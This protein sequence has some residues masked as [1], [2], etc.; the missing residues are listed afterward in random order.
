MSLSAKFDTSKIKARFDA[1]A[2]NAEVAARPAA[3]AG[4]QVYYDEVKVRVP[5]GQSVH[6]TKGKKQTFQPGNLKASI[7]QAYVEKESGDGAATYRV[8]YNKK[9][10]FYGYFVEH[11]TSKMAAKPFLRPSYDARRQDAINA[12]LEVLRKRVKV[13]NAR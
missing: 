3:Q 7:Y 4:I 1:L 10:A 6:Y 8:S 11:G 9:K 5:V 12:A 2:K 13:G